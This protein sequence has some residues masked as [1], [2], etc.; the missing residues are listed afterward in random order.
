MRKPTPERRDDDLSVVHA[1]GRLRQVGDL[2]VRRQLQVGHFVRVL[3]QD[4][5]VRRLAHRADHFVV[6]L[7]ADQEDRVPLAREADRLQVDLRH[8][9]TGGVNGV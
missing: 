4:H 9:R 2:G 1:Q 3:Y 5:V 7:V 6:A 8:Q